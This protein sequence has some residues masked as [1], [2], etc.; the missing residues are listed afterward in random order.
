MRFTLALLLLMNA[1]SLFAQNDIKTATARKFMQQAVLERLES[2]RIDPADAKRLYQDNSLFVGKCQICEG[3]QAAFREYAAKD[4]TAAGTAFTPADTALF[5]A[6]K[7]TKLKAL[8]KLVNTAVTGYY[9]KHRFNKKQ[10]RE[11]QAKLETEKKKSDM[12]TNGRY[13]ASC[14]G[15][16]KKPS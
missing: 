8:E 4:I 16:C 2:Q 12:M 14:T 6:N 7:E 1:A 13:C 5:S 3:S 15:S 10:R 11:M 9:K